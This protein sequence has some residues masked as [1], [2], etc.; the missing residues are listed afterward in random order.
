MEMLETWVNDKLHDIVGISDKHIT[1]YMI[2]LAKKAATTD[3][4]VESIKDTGVID[5]DTNV[6]NFARELWGKVP[7]KIQAERLG[8]KQEREALEL[9]KK[10]DNYKVL[11]DDE[12]EEETYIPKKKEKKDRKQKHFRKKR[13][14]SEESSEEDIPM[15]LDQ[16][17]PLSDSGS[18]EFDKQEQERLQDIDERDQF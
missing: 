16:D 18:D 15:N 14:S 9:Q 1:Q 6:L 17:D 2:G 10:N 13:E 7:H 8:R 11:S 12:S 3:H 4:F 5:I